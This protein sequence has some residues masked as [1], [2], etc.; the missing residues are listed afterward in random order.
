MF[1][2][3][4]TLAGLFS[5]STTA[6]EQESPIHEAVYHQFGSLDMHRAPLYG[7]EGVNPATGLPMMGAVDV[8]G[9]PYG[10][11]LSDTIFPSHESH[12]SL[13]DDLSSS[14]TSNDHCSND[15]MSG[16]RDSSDSFGSGGFGSSWD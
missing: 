15:W 11:D 4:D 6:T 14:W 9:S 10:A 7:H 5:T 8:G 3:F 2:F 16:S 12:D 1:N 13:S